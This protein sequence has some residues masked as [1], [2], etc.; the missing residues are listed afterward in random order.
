VGPEVPSSA[1]NFMPDPL[2]KFDRPPVVE[3]VLSAQFSRLPKFRTAH[4]G[5]FR[6]SHL[7]KDWDTLEEQPRIDDFFER[8]GEERKWG[9]MA[10]LR[11][12]T[13][14]EAQRTQIVG[15]DPTRMIQIQDSRFIY[16]WKSSS[17]GLYPSYAAT[18]Q[19]FDRLYTR[20]R[21]FVATYKLGDLEENQ[22]EVS[23]V[24]QI[25]KGGLWNSP[26]DWISIFP[27]LVPPKGYLPPDGVQ[28]NWDLVIPENRGRLHVTLYYG[29]TTMDGPEAIL[30]NLVAR[31][32][33]SSGFSIFDGFNIGHEAIVRSFTDMTTPRAHE[34]WERTQ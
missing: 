9:P 23:Y 16:N 13:S 12:T 17:I 10:G 30:L 14:Q 27:W 29:R 28:T 24:N 3:T 5:V 34:F 26:D 21:D 1:I 19:E 4:A 7:G 25:K 8:F 2:P 22:W 6:E 15:T 33:V 18:K 32:P 20:F 31:G 11:L